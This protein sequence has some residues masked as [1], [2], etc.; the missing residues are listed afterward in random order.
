MRGPTAI[1]LDVPA[2]GSSVFQTMLEVPDHVTGVPL[3]ALVAVPPGPRNCGQSAAVARVER[4]AKASALGRYA[5]I[6]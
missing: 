4:M 5:C 3:S 2:P 1:A 6:A